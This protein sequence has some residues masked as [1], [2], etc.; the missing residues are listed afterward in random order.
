VAKYLVTMEIARVNPLLLLDQLARVLRESILLS[1]ETLIN[2]KAQGK[3]TTG[4][5][6]I[7]QRYVWFVAEADSEVELQE[8]L[9]GLPLLGI[10]NTKTTDA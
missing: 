2:L 7:G 6:P 5:Y 9:E 3:V 8:V 4:G 10:A 1:V